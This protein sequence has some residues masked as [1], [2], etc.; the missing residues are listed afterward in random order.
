MIKK[1]YKPLLYFGIVFVLLVLF[2][3]F[4]LFRSVQNIAAK[5]LS[6]VLSPIY[7]FSLNISRIY[8]QQTDRRDLNQVVKELESSVSRLTAENLRLMLLEEENRSLRQHLTFLSSKQSHYVMSNIIYGGDPNLVNQQ[9]VIDRG[10]RDGVMAGLM[11]LDNNGQVVGK[12]LSVEDSTASICLVTN[13]SCQFAATVMNKNKTVGVTKGELGLT[14][15]M[16]FIPQ[17]E[18]INKGDQVFT[19]GLEKN[20]PRGYVIGR[21]AEVKK[22][23]NA[24]WQTAKIESLSNLNELS[25]VS[26]ILP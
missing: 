24:L 9:L 11:I 21:V 1:K 12:V 5:A 8:S 20:I 7:G 14:I 3:S 2:G 19:S 13:S 22:E 16:D 23:N 26:V 6:P 18:A 10:L 17:T 15:K 4:G 25:T